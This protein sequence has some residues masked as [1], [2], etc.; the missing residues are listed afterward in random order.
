MQKILIE[1]SD[2]DEIPIN[3][4]PLSEVLEDIKAEMKQIQEAENQI[5]G[6]GSWKFVGKCLDIIDKH[7]KRED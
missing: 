3:A 1:I 7:M 6:S 4:T 5:Y 2:T